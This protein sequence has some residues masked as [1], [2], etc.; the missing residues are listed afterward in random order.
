MI[1]SSQHEPLLIEQL[2]ITPCSTSGQQLA[3]YGLMLIQTGVGEYIVN[4]NR[5]VCQAGDVFF[6]GPSDTHSFNISQ[7][8]SF[9]RL[10]FSKS[11]LANL[12]TTNAHPWPHIQAYSAPFSGAIITNRTEQRNLLALVEII[13]AEQQRLCPLVA[14]PVVESLMKAILSLVDRHLAQHSFGVD[15]PST[16]PSTFIQR[17][18]AYISQHITEPNLL[19]MENLA[20][21]FNYS[22]SHLAALFKQQVGDSIQQYIIRYKLKQVETRL[23]LS[24]MT[25]SQ[26]ADEFG[27]SDVCH[28]NKLFKRYY[29]H[30]PTNYRR[31]MSLF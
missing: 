7:K 11:Y 15:L 21:V 23:S 10:S 8:T 14:N 28:L 22:A 2:D 29:Q 9:Y 31:S 24:T 5:Y 4:G 25:V 6:L 18:V 1:Y 16:T 20:D 17:V 13:L 3:H 30:T 12:A 27:F 19:R 26:I